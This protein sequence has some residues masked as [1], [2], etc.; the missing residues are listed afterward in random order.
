MA[1]ETKL[2]LYLHNRDSGDDLYDIL[3]DYRDDLVAS[4]G[5][6]DGNIR[7]IVHSFDERVEVATKLMSLGLHI[8]INGCSHKTPE[9]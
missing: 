3:L 1:I 5:V 8:G 2:P 7:G 9:K 6:D 4:Q